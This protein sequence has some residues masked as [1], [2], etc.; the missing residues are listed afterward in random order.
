MGFIRTNSREDKEVPSGAGNV[1][2]KGGT[3][4][5]IQKAAGGDIDAFGELYAIYL[6]RIYRYVFYQINDRMAAEDI[7]EE[8]FV[9]AWKAIGS[10]SGREATFS[11]WLYRI[12]RNRVVD[13]V[14]RQKKQVAIET[15]MPDG[16]VPGLAVE[17]RLER[18]ELLLVISRLPENQKQVI[19]LKF[20]EG[21]DNLEISHI[22]GKSQG[23]VRVLQM[24]GLSTLRRYLRKGTQR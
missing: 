6:D 16:D 12:A 11:A 9:K 15:D 20:I 19:L 10:C 22:M 7:T 4:L 17:G 24:R 2:D 21:M 8:V 14:R 18:E 13:S 1:P 3:A 23:S 5:L